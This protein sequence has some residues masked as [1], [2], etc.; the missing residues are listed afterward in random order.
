LKEPKINESHDIF[1]NIIRQVKD[2]Q[3]DRRRDEKITF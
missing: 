3:E 2:V 1:S